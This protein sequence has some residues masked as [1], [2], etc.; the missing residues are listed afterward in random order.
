MGRTRGISSPS[1]S[2]ILQPDTFELVSGALHRA[3]TLFNPD[4]PEH[5]ADATGEQLDEV[6]ASRQ[7]VV[8]LGDWV[9]IA[10]HFGKTAYGKVWKCW[11]GDLW[12]TAWMGEKLYCTGNSS[13]VELYFSVILLFS[14][15]WQNIYKEWLE[16]R[17]FAVND[18]NLT[19]HFKQWSA[20]TCLIEKH[21]KYY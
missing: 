11:M 3:W 20:M 10:P 15:D 1:L 7:R 13:I 21:Y 6:W 5:Y 12:P 17:Q 18:S 16:V 9:P 2:P 8:W 19:F 4:P 14:I